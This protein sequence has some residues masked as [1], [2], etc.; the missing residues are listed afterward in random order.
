LLAL[1]VSADMLSK[2]DVDVRGRTVDQMKL[3]L[4]MVVG[5]WSSGLAL[6]STILSDSFDDNSRDRSIWAKPFAGSYSSNSV[7]I[8]EYAEEN[9]RLEFTVSGITTNDF[10]VGAWQDSLR[11]LNAELNWSLTADIHNSADVTE[12]NIVE[13]GI[14]LYGH[15]WG[16]ESQEMGLWLRATSNGL[17]LYETAFYD[18]GGSEKLDFPE[19]LTPDGSIR[20]VYTASNQVMEIAYAN[21]P[22]N[23]YYT[24]KSIDTSVWNDIMNTGFILDTWAQSF[25]EEVEPG[26]VCLDNILVQDE[27]IDISVGSIF[28]ETTN[29]EAH[30]SIQ[31]EKS[32]DLVTWTNVGSAVEWVMPVEPQQQFFRVRS[33]P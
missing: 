18:Y 27:I 20:V 24:V 16:N 11:M 31:L 33:S 25:G 21:S 19:V 5:L 29:S 7:A 15:A 4:G 17:E 26:E 2:S 32:E 6:G 13:I 22:G 1:I 8:V 23:Q 10:G 14:G 28:L 12:S 3:L 9:Q 30:L